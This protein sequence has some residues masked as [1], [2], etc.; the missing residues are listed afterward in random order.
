MPDSG[1]QAKANGDKN[2]SSSSVVRDD[3]RS[4]LIS[5]RATGVGSEMR[6]V[7]GHPKSKESRNL[8]VN[9]GSSSTT[10]HGT[11]GD[12]RWDS[13]WHAGRRR[14]WQSLSA[15]IFCCFWPCASTSS[16]ASASSL[17]DPSLIQMYHTDQ[18]ATNGT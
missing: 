8:Q 18:S 2:Q 17:E 11:A 9:Y 3:E 7:L 16:D 12:A 10:S 5:E 15:G 13:S 4:G 14:A 1:D 6:I